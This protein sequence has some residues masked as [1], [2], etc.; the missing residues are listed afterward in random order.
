VNKAFIIFVVFGLYFIGCTTYKPIGFTGGYSDIPTDSENVA[1]TQFSGNGYTP[2]SGVSSFM[3][4]RLA[5]I[6]ITRGYR[7]F[8]LYDSNTDVSTSIGSYTTNRTQSSNSSFSGFSNG[9]A[10]KRE[11]HAG[12]IRGRVHP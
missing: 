8:Y 7:Y 12:T 4:T 9:G 5:E 10:G 1:I 3:L 6:T 11:S 2:S